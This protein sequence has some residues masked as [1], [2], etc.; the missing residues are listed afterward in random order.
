MSEAN[1]LRLAR[2]V[3]ESDFNKDRRPRVT[4][5]QL[6]TAFPHLCLRVGDVKPLLPALYAYA[7]HRVQTMALDPA[8]AKS[9]KQFSLCVCRTAAV[10]VRFGLGH[11]NMPTVNV[12]TYFSDR[13]TAFAVWMVAS[14]ARVTVRYSP[15]DRP[16]ETRLAL[17]QKLD[18]LD[19]K[20]SAKRLNFELERN[21]NALKSGVVGLNVGMRTLHVTFDTLIQILSNSKGSANTWGNHVNAALRIIFELDRSASEV[22]AFDANDESVSSGINT[23]VT[24]SSDNSHEQTSQTS[25]ESPDGVQENALSRSSDDGRERQS[26]SVPTQIAHRSEGS[27]ELAN[28]AV[29]SPVGDERGDASSGVT[30]D[31]M[32]TMLGSEPSGLDETS[33]AS[34]DHSRVLQDDVSGNTESFG[35]QLELS[36]ILLS[37]AERYDNALSDEPVVEDVLAQSKAYL[38]SRWQLAGRTQVLQAAVSRLSQRDTRL[39]VYVDCSNSAFREALSSSSNT[40]DAVTTLMFA[41]ASYVASL[42]PL[43]LDHKQLAKQIRVAHANGALQFALDHVDALP[44]TFQDVIWRLN[45]TWM[46]YRGTH[47]FSFTPNDWKMTRAD[48]I[49]TDPRKEAVKR[50]CGSG[51]PANWQ[52]WLVDRV[53]MGQSF[54][55]LLH[56]KDAVARGHSSRIA[57]A[58]ESLLESLKRHADDPQAT[59]NTFGSIILS[60]HIVRNAR[61]LTYYEPNT[62]GLKLVLPNALAAQPA[63]DA[64]HAFRSA[65]LVEMSTGQDRSEVFTFSAPGIREAAA[66]SAWAALISHFGL[67]AS[68]ELLTAPCVQ[69]AAN[70]M[71]LLVHSAH[72]SAEKTFEWIV[73]SFQPFESAWHYELQALIED[74]G[75]LLRRRYSTGC[76]MLV[77]N[78][79]GALVPTFRQRIAWWKFEA[80]REVTI[81][82]LRLLTLLDRGQAIGILRQVFQHQ[83]RF[84]T[85]TLRAMA[86]CAQ[87]FVGAWPP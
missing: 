34:G 7:A 50:I 22:K 70:A 6:Q 80:E 13:E 25:N 83:G 17:E 74:N 30:D 39:G 21:R 14:Q 27:N 40:R 20:I 35:T 16:D 18:A 47:T 24:A 11:I 57:V 8:S 67:G 56:V 75:R 15:D 63:L 46:S 26:N 65:V 3:M 68:N 64:V 32:R 45:H 52:S 41:I 86:E 5:E 84:E 12:H 31:V 53:W 10:Y 48:L 76:D 60:N 77:T 37:L 23:L 78:I 43:Q 42:T 2:V 71:H 9:I 36:E 29:I 72:D 85:K 87:A 61:A 58:I 69:T 62:E 81:G 66:A 55:G 38:V 51:V 19:E 44:A 54:R 82:T 49:F 28:G 59:V 1:Q 4:E 73:Q 79:V 33:D